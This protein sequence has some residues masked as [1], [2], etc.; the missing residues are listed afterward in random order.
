MIDSKLHKPASARFLRKLLAGLYDWLLVIALMMLTSVPFVALSGAPV[1]AGSSW[2]QGAMLAVAAGFF[3][4]FW[5]CGGQTVGMRAWRLQLVSASGP[6]TWSQVW[7]RFGAAWLSALPVGAGF[8]WALFDQDHL[9]W[10]DRLSATR[11]VQLPP[12]QK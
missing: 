2:Y 1:A 7:I 4:G 8:W 5:R 9:S 11:V 12:R 6:V 10:H 3:C